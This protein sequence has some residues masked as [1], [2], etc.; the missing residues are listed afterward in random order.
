MELILT[1]EISPYDY[2]KNEYESPK[3]S[4]EECPDEWNAFWQKSISESH[5]NNLKAIKNGSYLVNIATI[6][7]AEL[8]EIVKQELKEVEWDSFEDQIG[9]LS[10]GIVLKE[11]GILHIEPMCCSDIGTTKDWEQI[12]VTT[13]DNWTQLWIGHPWVFYKRSNG[14]IEFSDYTEFNLEDFKDIKSVVSVSETALKNQL[15]DIRKQQ[16]EFEIKIRDVLN[17]MKIPHSEYISK[18]MIGNI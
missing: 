3:G 13:T 15:S 2:A 4:I 18:S 16:N 5:L 10:G 17:K 9:K 8:E 14:R 11:N 7:E 12:F 1:I 6:N